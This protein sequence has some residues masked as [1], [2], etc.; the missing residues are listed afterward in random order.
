MSVRFLRTEVL[1]EAMS[2]DRVSVYTPGMRRGRIL[3][4][5]EVATGEIAGDMGTGNLTEGVILP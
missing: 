2:D 1:P 3:N 5:Y 4:P